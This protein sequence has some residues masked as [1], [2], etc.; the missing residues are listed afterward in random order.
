MALTVRAIGATVDGVEIRRLREKAKLTREEFAVKAGVPYGTLVAIEQGK[1]P[2]CKA[3]TL[4]LI[5]DLLG[6]SMEALL[7]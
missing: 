3:S 4:K 1:Y 6:S 2:D 5:A 7:K